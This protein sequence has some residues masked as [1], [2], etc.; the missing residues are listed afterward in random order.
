[1][2]RPDRSAEIDAALLARVAQHPHDLVAVVGQAL[3]LTRQTIAARA[4]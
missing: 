1:M 3:G 4:P 2:P